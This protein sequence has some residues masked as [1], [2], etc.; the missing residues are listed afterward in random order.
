[1]GIGPRK[2]FYLQRIYSLLRVRLERKVF[3]RCTLATLTLSPLRSATYVIKENKQ[4]IR[5]ASHVA[6]MAEM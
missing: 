2:G 6:L 1:M 3:E 4:R 5:G